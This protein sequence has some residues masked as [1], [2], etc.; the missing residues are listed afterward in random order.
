MDENY[1]DYNF[2]RAICIE[3]EARK[4]VFKH[5]ILNPVEYIIQNN[6][7]TFAKKCF[8]Q[9]KGIP[10]GMCISYILSSFYYSCLE[11]QALRFMKQSTALDCIMRLTDDY[12]LM[13]SSK[14]NALLFIERLFALATENGFSFNAKKLKTNFSFNIDKLT[15]AQVRT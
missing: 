10:Q 12:L 3:A 8:K 7:V 5:E 13:T 14:S 2:K 1:F 15:R 6:Y 9:T 4:K 11:E